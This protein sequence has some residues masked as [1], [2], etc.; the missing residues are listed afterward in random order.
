MVKTQQREQIN[1]IEIA[2]DELTEPQI[3]DVF[4]KVVGRPVHYSPEPTQFSSDDT[5]NAEGNKMLDW[6]NREGYK[7]DIP[8]LRAIY[9]PLMTLETWARRS[10]WENAEPVSMPATGWGQNS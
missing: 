8:A 10:G 3:A 7:A 2:G 9:P 6:F 1:S 4:T 5:Q